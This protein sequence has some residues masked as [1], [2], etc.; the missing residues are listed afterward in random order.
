MD[1]L[2]K[3]AYAK[4]WDTL[5]KELNQIGPPKRS[6]QQWRKIWSGHKYDKKR[7]QAEL[8]EPNTKFFAVANKTIA[9]DL[10]A[11]KASSLGGKSSVPTIRLQRKSITIGNS[12]SE[13]NVHLYFIILYAMEF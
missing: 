7:K 3:I 8:S 5:A 2:G 6:S 9:A 4:G 11:P 10:I 1:N 12:S 13:G